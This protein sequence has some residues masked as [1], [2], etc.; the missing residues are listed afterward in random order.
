MLVEDDLGAQQLVRRALSRTEGS[1]EYVLEMARDLAT[2]TKALQCKRF[3][4][5]LLDLALPDS[6]GVETVN[7]VRKLA[8]DIPIL[9]LSALS[10]PEYGI[11]AIQS[12]ADYYLPKGN[13]AQQFLGPSIRYCIERKRFQSTPAQTD[14]V[15]SSSD[16]P[17]ALPSQ[18]DDLQHQLEQAR[19]KNQDLESLLQRIRQDFMTIFDAAPAMIWYR[20][21]HGVI[22]RA[23]RAAAQQ[24]GLSVREIVGQN[25]FALFNE[26]EGRILDQQVIQSGIPQFGFIRR[27]ETP[28]G[29]RWFQSDRIPYRQSNGRIVGLIVFERDITQQKQTEEALVQS[30]TRIEQMNNHLQKAVLQ[31]EQANSAKSE[32]LARMSHE[33][34][35]PM[36][37]IIGFSELLLDEPLTDS[38]QT[39]ART[40]FDCSHGLLSLINDI[41]DFS[42]IEAGRLDIEWFP[43]DLPDLLNEIAALFEAGIREK[44]LTLDID[45]DPATPKQ[46]TTDPGRLRQ[47]MVNLI[48]NAVKFTDSGFVR[49]RL[50]PQ[51]QTPDSDLCIEISD[52]GIGIE[53]DTINA[54]FNPYVQ[55]DP[56]TTRRYGG[57][58]LGLAITHKLIHLLGGQIRVVSNPGKGSAFTLVIPRQPKSP[59]PSQTGTDRQSSSSVLPPAVIDPL[60]ALA[61]LARIL[62]IE[63][64]SA[65]QIMMKLML[66]RLGY[67][68]E[69]VSKTNKA[70]QMAQSNSFDLILTNR[71]LEDGDGFDIVRQLRRDKLTI[72]IVLATTDTRPTLQTES[73]AAGCTACIHQPVTRHHLRDILRTLLP[74]RTRKEG[75]NSR[76]IRLIRQLSGFLNSG[77][78]YRAIR[79]IQCLMNACRSADLPGPLQEA[80]TLLKQVV[81]EQWDTA[82]QTLVRMEK[83]ITSQVPQVLSA[84]TG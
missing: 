5:I 14:P 9:V 45:Y 69:C 81:A 83:T 26:S 30:N 17:L 2:A 62:V 61:P 16:S 46:I 44:G 72:P 43:C 64:D 36:N 73:V 41:L 3:D 18:S 56:S 12:G 42:K 67:E 32:F 20:D 49:I 55:G 50:H 60:N 40:I 7:K 23:N 24:T 27:L 51:S 25:Y 38:Q 6:Q 13:I 71:H 82:R 68:V 33:I 59:Q 74:G 28:V 39:F 80:E 48:S 78:R 37:A 31:A 8:H 19:I 52:T 66:H 35:T 11:K 29:I 76:I 53:P 34:R 4:N 70:L 63:G 77:Y 22:L 1:E 21:L 84:A 47:C 54:I 65:T 75:G 79:L 15:P 57:T 10:E 58:G